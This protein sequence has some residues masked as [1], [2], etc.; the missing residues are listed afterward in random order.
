[1]TWKNSVTMSTG[2]FPCPSVDSFVVEQPRGTNSPIDAFYAASGH[3]LTKS[4][5]AFDNEYGEDF[6]GL[7]FVGLISA[8]E[9]YFRD[10]LGEILSICPVAQNQAA[11]EKVQLGSLLWGPTNLHNRSAFEFLAFSSAK[12]VKET[13]NKFIAHTISQHGVWNSMLVE[14]DKLCEFRHAVVHSGHIIAGKNALKLNLKPSKRVL[15]LT[16][17][18]GRLQAAG[19]VCTAFVQAANIELFEMLVSRWAVS[20]RKLPSW[21]PEQEQCLKK[22]HSTFLSKR[23]KK[24]R[25]LITELTYTDFLKAVELDFNL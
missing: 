18:Y 23:D 3:I 10:I 17:D 11:D 14:Y 6:V 5:P 20:W 16:M 21:S 24:N 8:T 25:T 12:N 19:R 15:K 1:M 13:F 22:I 7:L 4:S 9:N 2:H